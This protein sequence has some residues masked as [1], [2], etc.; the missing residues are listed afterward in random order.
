MGK[1]GMHLLEVFEALVATAQPEAF[2]ALRAMAVARTGTRMP[3]VFEALLA[4]ARAKAGMH[5]P[6]VCDTLWA[7]RPMRLIED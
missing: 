6:E 1:A 7:A 5:M 2:E 3:E 4:T